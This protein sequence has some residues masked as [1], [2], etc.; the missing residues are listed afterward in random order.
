MERYLPRIIDDIIDKKLKTVGA[1]LIEGPKW[2]GKSTTGKKHVKSIVEFQD[3][4][5]KNYYDNINNTRPSMFLDEEKPLMIDEWQMY[6]V[7]WDAIR[8]DVDKT[9]KQGQYILTGSARPIEGS[10]THT[11]TG[12]IARILMR[13]MSLYESGDSDGKISLNDLFKGEVQTNVKS[14]FKF[15]DIIKCI[16]RGGWPLTLFLEDQNEVAKNYFQSLTHEGIKND[17]VIEYNSDRLSKVIKSLARNISSITNISTIEED[18]KANSETFSRNLLENYIKTL[19]DLYILENVPAWNGKIRS[20]I[21]IRTK[22]KIQFVDPSLACVSLGAT[23]E[24]LKKDLNT[25][26]LLFESLCIRDL[27]IYADSID[28]KV[29]YYRD[30]TGLEVDAIIELQNGDWGAIEIKLGEGYIKEAE[31]NLLKFKNKV[32][33]EKIGEPKFLGIISS[34]EYSYRT[35]NGIY[36]ISIGNLK[37]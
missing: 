14:K 28:G 18:V 20:K 11:G 3:V 19:K 32:D 26:G 15:D 29:Y 30:E 25:L 5:K 23:E 37:N 4:D 6:P 9:G 33:V 7:V 1:I 2:C 12:R 24:S 16:I 17:S 34:T 35:E 27:R 22:E 8:N 36:V 31:E 21:A 10:I 13:P